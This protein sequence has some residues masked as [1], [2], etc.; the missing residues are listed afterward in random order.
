MDDYKP[1]DE[2][3]YGSSNGDLDAFLDNID[4]GLT[5]Q[6]GPN[7]QEIFS[8]GKVI[9]EFDWGPSVGS[10]FNWEDFEVPEQPPVEDE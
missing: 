7:H 9:S 1:G 3:E 10:E 4:K 6:F 5:D 2:F 8:N